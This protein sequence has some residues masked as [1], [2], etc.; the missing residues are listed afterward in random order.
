MSTV[1]LVVLASLLVAAPAA[2]QEVTPVK[3][4]AFDVIGRLRQPGYAVSQANRVQCGVTAN[5]FGMSDPVA[6]CPWPAGT[7]NNYLYAAGLQIAGL[8]GPQAAGW[9]GDTAGG[10]FYDPKGTTMHGD[11]QTGVWSSVVA[12]DRARWPESALVPSGAAGSIYASDLQ[13]RIAASDGDLWSLT[14][15]TNVNLANGR[16]HPLG[17]A[18]ETRV[19]GWGYPRGNEDI[20]YVNY[21]IHNITATNPAVY[22]G[23]RS[24]IRGTLLD[25]ARRFHQD[26]GAK[27]GI[28]LPADG[29]TIERFFTAFT[30]DADVGSAGANYAS[31]NLP[32][33]LAFTYDHGFVPQPQFQYDVADHGAPF[34]ASTGFLGAKVLAAPAGGNAIRLMNVSINGSPFGS[35]PEPRDVTQLYRYL[36]A[37]VSTALGDQSCNAG[38][39]QV[40]HICFINN[41]SAQDTRQFMSS[42]G[43]DLLPGQSANY[44]VAL[45]FAAPFGGCVVNCTDVKPGDPRRIGNDMQVAVGVNLVDSLTGYSGFTDRNGDGLPQAGEIRAHTRSLLGKAQMAQALFDA[46]F[47]LPRPPVAPGFYLIPGD[48]RVSI[49]WQPSPTETTGDPYYALASAPTRV[50]AQGQTEINP[51]YDPN[52]RQFDVEGYRIYRG[53]SSDPATM[54]LLAQFDY[55]GTTISDYAGRVNPVSTCAPELGVKTGC[56]VLFDSLVPGVALTV[57]R[58]LPLSGLVVQLRDGDRTA[59]RDGS[60]S[61]LRTDSIGEPGTPTCLCDT[62]V[63]FQFTDSSVS[64]GSEYF[65]AVVAFDVNSA[66]SAPS[67]MESARQL[68]RV[69]PTRPATNVTSTSS[70][71]LSLEGRGRVLDTGLPTPTFNP[72]S[73]RFS[74]PFPP[75]NFWS[76]TLPDFVPEVVSGTSETRIRLD[77]LTLGQGGLTGLSNGREDLPVLFHLTLSSAGGVTRVVLPIPQS[78]LGAL[79]THPP[80]AATLP[81]GETDP[82]LASRYGGQVGPVHLDLRIGLQ[83]VRYSGEWGLNSSLSPFSDPT[84]NGIRWFDGPSPERNEVVDH[85]TAANC[86][87]CGGQDGFNNAGSLAG[88]QTV[89]QPLSY[90]MFDR[91][92]RN[93]AAS[94]AG[95][96][97]AAD[98]N[99]YWG[100]NGA[101]D[102]VIDITHNVPVPFSTEAG[103]TWGILNTSAQGDGGFDN[104]PAVLTPTDW[105]CVEPFRSRLTQPTN[106]WFPCASATAFRLSPQAVPGTIA[107]G[108]GDPLNATQVYGVRNPANV[109]ALP[110][111]ALYVAGTISQFELAALPPRGTV[112]S[113]R[114]Y[115]GSVAGGGNQFPQFTPAP[116][117][118]TAVGTEL[119]L[120][121]EARNSVVLAKTGDL[122]RV[123]TVPDPFYLNTTFLEGS[124]GIRFVNLPASAIIRIY[125]S[126]GVL[127]RVIEHHP[128]TQTG[129]TFWDLRTRNNQRVASGVYFYQVEAGGGAARR[130]GRM[131]IVNFN[132]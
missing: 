71:S 57:G 40:S 46:H 32:L 115:V 28:A 15:E 70:F 44:S 27:Y 132:N 110:G 131:T 92:W 14:R 119:V 30:A 64:N 117:P 66:Q 129:D 114:D 49:L 105:S 106:V 87:I 9:V 113:L 7:R 12:G 88:V 125:S 81:V 47:L 93:M 61:L 109:A 3:A 16:K 33:S 45:I 8:I 102:S 99:V 91:S 123:H 31:V 96:R 26:V 98:Y 43:G 97:R 104:R 75:A 59:L 60:V 25:L 39:P 55:A 10:Y 65:Y 11:D 23:E 67:S 107:F 84:P 51:L 121:Y 17:V 22:A 63:P 76:G 95:A 108:A 24:E 5:D 74:G 35:A 54:T 112:W 77:S 62:G 80:S 86:F 52:Y 38:L 101:I 29:Y 94:L 34:F 127:L 42:D 18:V 68:K 58:T 73:E 111:F 103:G 20:L 130:V 90:V 69:R 36:G 124:E 13:G 72:V 2:A 122:R 126:S 37:T 53:R 78:G 19:V 100:D 4:R 82:A 89:Y 21:T 56:P 41:T 128:V 83:P 118:W 85:P 6:K 79:V 1:R 50:N 120:R 48:N 116:R